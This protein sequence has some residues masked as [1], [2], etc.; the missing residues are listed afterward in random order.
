MNIDHQT[1][2]TFFSADCFNRVWEL[3][4]KRD[5]NREDDERMISLAHASLAH[6]RM[7]DDCVPRNLSIGFWQISR[8][9]AV[10]GQAKNAMHYG[11]LC[12]EVSAPEPPFYLGYAH[13]ALARAALLKGNKLLLDFHLTE[14]RRFAGLVSIAEER[15]ML[16]DDLDTLR[17]P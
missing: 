12:L 13:E 10:L 6:W 3:L 11:R 5:R 14:A 4:E 15:K 9:Y 7:R 1:A 17:Q 2:H 8:V 16:D